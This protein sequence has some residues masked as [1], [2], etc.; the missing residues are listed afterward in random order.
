MSFVLYPNVIQLLPALICPIN[1]C[2]ADD[3]NILRHFLNVTQPPSEDGAPGYSILVEL[4]NNLAELWSSLNPQE[5][6][7]S[8]DYLKGVSMNTFA[9]THVMPDIYCP[10]QQ[11]GISGHPTDRYYRKYPTKKAQIPVLVLH[12]ELDQVLPLP[13]ARHF[14]QKYSLVNSNVAYIELPRTGHTPTSKYRF[15]ID[16][17]D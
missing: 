2:N 10:T 17:K 12:G 6:N 1:R 15:V 5:A 9:S 16:F 14:F 8:C 13:I 11:T 3:Q 7:P 4:N